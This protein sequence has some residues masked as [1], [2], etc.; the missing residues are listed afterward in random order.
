[1]TQQWQKL[2]RDF[3]GVPDW[4]NELSVE[5]QQY[6]DG[7][8]PGAWILSGSLP[9]QYRNQFE[10]IARSA[11]KE[12]ITD[13]AIGLHLSNEVIQ[14][15]DDLSRWF[16]AIQ[17]L[18]DGYR[19][20]QLKWESDD[21]QTRFAINCGRIDRPLQASISLCQYL[22]AQ[23]NAIE[24]RVEE[25]TNARMKTPTEDSFAQADVPKRRGR[26]TD[27]KIAARKEITKSILKSRKDWNNPDKIKDLFEAHKEARD[28]KD[29]LLSA[30]RSS[31]DDVARTS[32]NEKYVNPKHPKPGRLPT[33]AFLP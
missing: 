33:Q 21:A 6:R 25:D 31:P 13:P 17:Y 9:E 19:E 24:E 15:P 12:L 5:R 4:H 32:D 14:E 29:W 7:M 1:M 23:G 20:P 22:A 27:A 30:S 11:G 28:R 18:T 2:A 10:E 16:T 26:T 3:R 8:P